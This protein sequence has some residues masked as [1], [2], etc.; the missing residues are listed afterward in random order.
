MLLATPIASAHADGPAPAVSAVNGKISS[1]GGVTGI[2]GESSGVAVIKGSI[3]TPLGH[4]FGFQLDGTAGTA[5]NAGFGGGTAHL[6]WRDPAIGL[7]GAVA[8]LEGGSGIRL[9]WY[10]AE[11]EYFAG[12]FTFGAWGGYHEAV[13]NRFG[14]SASS[15]SYGGSLTVYPIPDLAVSLGVMSEFSRATGGGVLEWQP[16]L[17]ARHNVSFYVEGGVGDQSSY[18]VTAGV[19][20]YFGP[21]KPL[22]RRH[23]EDD[24]PQLANLVA[25]NFFGQNLPAIADMEAQ[26]EEM[27]AQDVAAMTGYHSGAHL[28]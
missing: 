27:W 11:A 23:R 22:I 13:D 21:D 16:D 8:S 10:G 25:S 18:S 6:F 12:I 24:P 4:A 7:V 17:F 19:R 2:D 1:E 3:T 26:Y 9:G 28:P 5:F 15:G 14:I 20:F